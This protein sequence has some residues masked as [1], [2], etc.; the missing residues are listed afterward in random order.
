MNRQHAMERAA[1][2]RFLARARAAGVE[3]VRD[4]FDRYMRLNSV[5]RTQLA[6]RLGCDSDGLDRMRLC[7]I[8]RRSHF[9]IDVAAIAALGEANA[10]PLDLLL[11][12][13]VAANQ[14]TMAAEP[15]APYSVDPDN[16]E[17]A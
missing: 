16:P 13:F 11:R 3:L 17:S 4:A 5:D 14:H 2:R 9:H 10:A 6:E 8:P 12:A 1:Q 15:P 7:K